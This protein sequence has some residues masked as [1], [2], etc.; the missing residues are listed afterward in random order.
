MST[1][2]KPVML[3]TRHGRIGFRQAK[4]QAEIDTANAK[5]REFEAQGVFSTKQVELGIMAIRKAN[6]ELPD[7]LD[8]TGK[9]FERLG[10]Q[11]QGAIK[12]VCSTGFNGLQQQF[13]SSG[14]AT[15]EGIEQ[16]HQ[17][18]SPSGSTVWV[19]QEP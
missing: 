12:A 19:M 11:N 14:E 9:A 10:H 18:S 1:G 6:A 8:E 2:N 15:A 3:L 16:A 13:E 17:K 7:E 4:S 5:M